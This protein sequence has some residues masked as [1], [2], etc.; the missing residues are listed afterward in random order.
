MMKIKNAMLLLSLI[1]AG[2]FIARETLS[3]KRVESSRQTFNPKSGIENAPIKCNVEAFR[4]G[5]ASDQPKTS[6]IRA[7]PIKN[8]AVLRTVTTT[9]E[10]VHSITGSDGK[11]WFEISK[12]LGVS[13]G[14]VTLFEGRG[15][16]H[17]S[18]LDLS[19]AGG[20]HKLRAL[21]NKNSRAIKNLTGEISEARPLSC[22]G[23]WMKIKSGK[24]IGWLSRDGQCANPLT[25]CS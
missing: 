14:D 8:S 25:T 20:V 21:P 2:S 16:V 11:G 18:L 5:Y 9:D 19:V 10:V 4:L 23:T 1:V 15:W 17:S 7:A 3:Q 6:V 24:S 12:I 13:D 22:Q